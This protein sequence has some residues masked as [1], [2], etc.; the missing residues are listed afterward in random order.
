[1]QLFIIEVSAINN[2]YMM[3]MFLCKFSLIFRISI[4]HQI[5]GIK[6]KV[7]KTKPI[8]NHRACMQCIHLYLFMFS[9]LVFF[10]NQNNLT[11]KPNKQKQHKH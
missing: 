3:Y 2:H 1:M 9:P 8:T 5:K 4:I 10:I 7:I 11:V 6:M